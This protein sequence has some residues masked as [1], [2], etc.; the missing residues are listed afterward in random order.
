MKIFLISLSFFFFSESFAA[1]YTPEEGKGIIILGLR[2]YNSSFSFDSEREKKGNPDNDTFS[3][4]QL[5]YFWEHGLAPKWSL[6]A[7]GTIFGEVKVESDIRSDS[8]QSLGHQEIGL[9]YNYAL[10]DNWR[11]SIQVSTA[12]PLYS[13]SGNPLIGNHQHDIEI[14]HLWDD[15]TNTFLSYEIFELAFR[16]RF[17]QPADEIRASYTAGKNWGVHGIFFQSYLSYGLRN[18]DGV[19]VESNTNLSSDFDQLV[20]GLNYTYNFRPTWTV[21]FGYYRDIW[22]RTV[23]AGDTCVLNLWKSY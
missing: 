2:S 17:D 9:K 16:L 3:R 23:S 15:L 5:D 21:Q 7:F 14:R 22:G 19:G 11:R 1:A 6:F 12:F 18:Q 20:A 4:L 8:N 10:S 13:R